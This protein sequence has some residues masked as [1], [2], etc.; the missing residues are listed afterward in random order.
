M[1][2]H[3]STPDDKEK[4]MRWLVFKDRVSC[5]STAWLESKNCA[6]EIAKLWKHACP[7]SPCVKEAH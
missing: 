7:R 5:H 3:V 4:I 1:P 6:K 2:N